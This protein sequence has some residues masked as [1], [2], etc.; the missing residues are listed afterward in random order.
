MSDKYLT[1]RQLDELFTDWKEKNFKTLF[2]QCLQ[3][4]TDNG[5]IDFD[6][7]GFTLPLPEVDE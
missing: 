5:D 2:K 1:V 3:D 6:G 7:Q 4:L